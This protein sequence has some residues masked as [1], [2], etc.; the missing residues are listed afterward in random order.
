MPD[1][2]IPGDVL[3]DGPV[4]GGL[5]PDGPSPD[6]VQTLLAGADGPLGGADAARVDALRARLAETAA[7]RDL[8]DVQFRTWDSPVG[9]LLIART[10]LG[11]ASITFDGGAPDRTLDTLARELG[12]RVLRAP[13]ALDDAVCALDEYFAGRRE[14]FD[15]ALDLRRARGFRREVVEQLQAIP[16]GRTW[17]YGHVATALDNPGAVRA[18]GTACRLNPLP[19]VVPCHRVVR[20]DGTLGQYAGG[21]R[22][23]ELLLELEHAR[24]A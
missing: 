21:A 4:A 20:S 1:D 6:D 19:I 16:Y 7:D 18:V 9:I 8:L 11:L 12:P 14:R 17:T 2:T 23:K 13:A 10:P 22:A 5:G 24:P 3:P 15:L